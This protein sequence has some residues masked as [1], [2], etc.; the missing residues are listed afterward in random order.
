MKRIF[1][2]ANVLFTAAH[3]PHGKAAFLVELGRAGHWKLFSS[4]YALAEARRNLEIKFPVRLPE[5]ETLRDGVNI[6]KHHDNDI[7]LPGLGQKDQP[8][9]QAAIKCAATH[10]ITGDKKDFGKFMNKPRQTFNIRIQTPA[11][12]LKEFT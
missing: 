8:I 11:D 12:F 2:D 1:L 4:T 10:L 7:L 5:F 6:V 3:N 9:F